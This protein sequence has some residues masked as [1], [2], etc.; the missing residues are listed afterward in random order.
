MSKPEERVSRYAT[1][2]ITILEAYAVNRQRGVWPAVAA[3][4]AVAWF[5]MRVQVLDVDSYFIV[6]AEKQGE[7]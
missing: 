6:L 4:V 1:R 5:V 2:G 7:R 3:I